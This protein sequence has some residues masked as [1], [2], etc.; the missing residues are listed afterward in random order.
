MR[1]AK[2]PPK[3]LINLI[4]TDLNDLIYYVERLKKIKS[5]NC[6]I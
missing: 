4:G 3:S 5:K 1:Y 2:N 6:K